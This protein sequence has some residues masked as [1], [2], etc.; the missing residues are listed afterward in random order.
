MRIL[1][2]SP[3]DPESITGNAVTLRRIRDG[4][5]SR[6]HDFSVLPVMPH[7]AYDWVRAEVRKAAPDVVHLYHSYKTGR[8]AT[9]LKA[10]PCVVTVSGTDVNHD[11]QDPAK[12]PA[13]EIAL[14]H[15]AR[16]VTYNPSLAAQIRSTL[17]RVADKLRVIPKGVVLGDEPFDLRAA[18]GLPAGR[19]LF[20]HPG[21]IRAVKNN[22]FAVEALAGFREEL[23][24]V[25]AGPALEEPYASVFS[26]RIGRE[27]WVRHLP[28]IP[29]AAMAAAYRSSDVVLNTSLS[30]GISNA[31]ME[32]MSSGRAIL[33]SDIPGNRDLLRDGETGLLYRDR[34]DFEAKVKRLLSEPGL[35]RALGEAARREAQANF[36]RDRELDALLEA[37]AAAVADR[38]KGSI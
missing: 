23:S 2:L 22:T 4:L 10:W 5:R 29:P 8:L 24:L 16:I 3:F 30:E 34:A 33:A 1:A 32:A 14:D 25:F 37:Y 28:L 13:I 17:P 11:F 31:L 18:A 27:P 20:L 35:H 21:G 7:S 36:S 12:R 19:L 6:G 9:L 38:R 15:A 26:R